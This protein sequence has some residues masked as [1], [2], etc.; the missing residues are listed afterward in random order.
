MAGQGPVYLQVKKVLQG[1]STADYAR[2]FIND[3]NC[4]CF[5]GSQLGIVPTP[6]PRSDGS[7]ACAAEAVRALLS[8]AAEGIS[9]LSSGLH[10]WSTARPGGGTGS[11]RQVRSVSGV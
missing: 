10:H 1:E 2:N 8:P 7:E 6:G 11:L 3:S 5:M 4:I 9:A